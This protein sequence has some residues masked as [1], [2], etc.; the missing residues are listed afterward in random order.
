MVF[1]F[2][3]VQL[4]RNV[5]LYVTPWTVVCQASL[6]FNISQSLPKSMSTA[7]VMSSSHL[8]LWC[9]LSFFPQSLPASGTFPMSQLFTSD[10]Q[11]SGVS[12]LASVLPTS[13]QGRFSLRLT[14]LISLLS[15]E[16]LD[17]RS[18]LQ[19]HRS[20]ASI[21][22]HS[23]FLMVDLSQLYTVRYSLTTGKIIAFTIRTV[24]A[25]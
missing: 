3:S 1:Q 14:G 22:W 12:A 4:L 24:V 7:S 15:K 17:L 10:D 13:I 9:L 2:T 16:I 19:H 6:S 5:K 25:E 11:N 23:V 20:K 18:L 21:C 8:I